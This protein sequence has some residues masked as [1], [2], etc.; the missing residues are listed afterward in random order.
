MT[1][2]SL[3]IDSGPSLARERRSRSLRRL[4]RNV[5][6]VLGASLLLG[7]LTASILLPLVYPMDPYAVDVD[8]IG[9]APSWTHLFGTD[10]VGRDLFARVVLGIKTSLFVGASV[11]VL[12]CTVGLAVG[13]LA[14]Y[15]K[16][17]DAILMRVS[18]GM[19]AIPG[20]LLALALVATLGPQVQN[21][22]IALTVVMIPQVSRMVRVRAMAV[23]ELTY[24]EAMRAQGA[25]NS[26]ILLRHIAPNTFSILVV[27][28]AFIFADAV[29][30]EASLSFL[31]AGVPQPQPSLGNILFDGKQAIFSAW[32]VT[33]IPA[34]MLV[35]TVISLNL[36]GDG[37]RDIVDPKGTMPRR[38]NWSWRRKGPDD[39]GSE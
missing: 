1:T 27:Q 12:S 7:I 33:V 39:D 18:D 29:M 13:L 15:F 38:R 36:L 16:V 11:M 14:G 32:W 4:R 2:N 28:A 26:R 37:V 6:L 25:R 5:P 34:L 23:K 8:T 30:T 35:V 19:M 20:V 21:V 3:S 22:V 9:A 17:L 10:M 31:G 24:V